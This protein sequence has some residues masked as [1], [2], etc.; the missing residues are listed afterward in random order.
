MKTLKIIT[1]IACLVILMPFIACAQSSNFKL[2]GKIGNLNKPAMV[3]LDYMDNG[4]SHEDSTEL[5]NGAFSFSGQIADLATARMA[6]APNGGGKQFAIYRGGDAIYF[7]FGKEQIMMASKDS[8]SNALVTGSKTYDEFAAYTKTVGGSI[9][10]LTKAVNLDFA[11]GTPEQQKDTTYIKAVDARFRRAIAARN[12][13]QLK[14][15]RENPNSYFALVALSEAAGSKVDV[16]VVEPIYKTLKPQFKQTDMGIELAQRIK[17]A[18][19]IVVGNQAPLFTQND[20][21][22]KPLSLAALK[23]KVILIDFWASWCAPCRAENPNLAQQYQ[24]YK[25]KGFEILSVSLDSDKKNWT[26]AIQ[27]DGMPWKHVSDLKGWNN[28]V[29]RLYGIRAVPA[30]FLID[31]N[32]KIIATDIRGEGL[33]AKLAEIFNK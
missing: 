19:T 24:L 31:A 9:M 12:E 14:F 30:C 8:L 27:Q 17:A 11:S 4:K 26:G 5:I 13:K 33:N 21:T 16:A 1:G 23:G 20:E 29:G 28:M 6:L 7:Y 15:A 25:D 32:G 18:S 2:S 10:A 3:Y 22:G